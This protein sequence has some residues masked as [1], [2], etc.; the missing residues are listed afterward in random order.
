MAEQESS[1]DIIAEKRFDATTR[2]QFDSAYIVDFCD[3]L[4]AALKREKAELVNANA[5]LAKIV[6]IEKIG[7]FAALR[8][9][10]STLRTALKEIRNDVLDMV[11]N[12]KS[13]DE[14]SYTHRLCRSIG[15]ACD[16]ALDETKEFAN[17][18]E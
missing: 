12:H 11:M 14:D 9:A 6:D 13:E 15:G 17:A 7:N 3:R 1:T 5:G 18:D 4:D 10:I 2:D 8:E 16:M